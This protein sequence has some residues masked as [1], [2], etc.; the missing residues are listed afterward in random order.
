MNTQ[1]HAAYTLVEARARSEY[2]RVQLREV[3]VR[4]QAARSAARAQRRAER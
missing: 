1:L 2:D 4:R 3:Q